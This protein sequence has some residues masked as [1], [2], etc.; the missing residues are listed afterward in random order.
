MHFSE[1]DGPET[2]VPQ[3]AAFLFR[4]GFCWASDARPG[5]RVAVI[6]LPC[7]SA[8][9]GLVALGAMCKRLEVRDASDLGSH[10][11][12]IRD[13]AVKRSSERVLRHNVYSGRFAVDREDEHGMVWVRRL[14]PKA[15][16]STVV[17]PATANTWSFE[18]EAPVE[19]LRGDELPFAHFYSALVPNLRIEPSNL[20]RSD[21]AV[22][23]AGR[24]MGEGTSQRVIASIRLRQ[25]DESIELSRLLTVHSWLP[26]T[27]SRVTFY[28]SRTSEMDRCTAPPEIVV[29][30]G[31]TSF[32]RVCDADPFLESDVIGIIHRTTERDKLEAV[33]LK[34]AAL[35]QWYASDDQLPGGA[36][37]VPNGIF[38]SILRRS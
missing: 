27:V 37:P 36:G 17:F 1:A 18:G 19:V 33:G 10:F 20:S 12:R 9:A 3:W 28:N 32:L 31:D 24:V 35:G 21:S 6:S 5:R 38:T 11:N 26:K 16:F 29:A 23:L 13:L 14:P 15:G 7:D 30:D 34:L 22:C 8:A 2:G 4:L 25:N